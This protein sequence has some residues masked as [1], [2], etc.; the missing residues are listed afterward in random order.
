[1]VLPILHANGL[2]MTQTTDIMGDM[3]VVVTTIYHAETGDC[4]YGSY[5]LVSMDKNDPQKLGGSLTYARRY[6]LLALLGIATEDDDAASATKPS[7]YAKPA[8]NTSTAPQKDFAHVGPSP[9]ETEAGVCSI[10]GKSVAGKSVY[11]SNKKYGRTL[12]WDHQQMAADGTLDDPRENQI[13]E[14]T[15][16]ASRRF[17]EE[18]F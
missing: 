9:E 15:S 14:S 8:A 10:C 12:C 18:P 3:P 13:G 1:M 11:W 4:I 5:P 7:G 2:L 16:D 17:D 6:A